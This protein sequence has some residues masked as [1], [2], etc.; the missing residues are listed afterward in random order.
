LF[1]RKLSQ[2]GHL[3]DCEDKNQDFLE[4][5]MRILAHWLGAYTIKANLFCLQI[6]SL[7]EYL[8]SSTQLKNNSEDKFIMKA[9]ICFVALACCCGK[10]FFHSPSLVVA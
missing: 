9:F 5:A 3:E 4:M 6:I 10:L 2:V 8:I 1:Q 7:R